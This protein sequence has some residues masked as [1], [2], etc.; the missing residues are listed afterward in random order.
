MSDFNSHIFDV[1]YDLKKQCGKTEADDRQNTADGPRSLT[2]AAAIAQDYIA[3]S[4]T[5]QKCF[6]S[7]PVRDTF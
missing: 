6:K 2:R 3:N 7:S 4:Q 5:E 1:N